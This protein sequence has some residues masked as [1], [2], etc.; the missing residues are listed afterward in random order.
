ME[1]TSGLLSQPETGTDPFEY[2][3][4]WRSRVDGTTLP[5]LEHDWDETAEE[6]RRKQDYTQR[7]LTRKGRAPRFDLIPVRRRKAGPP[8]EIER[9]RCAEN[10][11]RPDR[12]GFCVDCGHEL[13]REP[14][15]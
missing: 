14:D 15:E 12:L 4:Q 8:E 6:A 10:E 7:A 11:C 9:D 1:E 5:V 2:A 13:M 3:V